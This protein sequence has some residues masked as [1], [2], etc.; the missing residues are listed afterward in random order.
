MVTKRKA[1]L[2]PLDDKKRIVVKIPE[3]PKFLMHLDADRDGKVDDDP[4]GLDVWT[5]G[6][7][8][9]G[10][11]ILVN[12][13]GKPTLIDNSDNKVN[14][15]ADLKDI[16]PLD[17][18]RTGPNPPAGWKV[19]LSVSAAD[20]KHIRIF[21]LR[22]AGG[23]EVIG[24][25]KGEKYVLPSLAFTKLEMGIE[26]VN[27]AGEYGGKPF[28]GDVVLTLS[29]DDKSSA[30]PTQTAKVRVA[31]W[32]MFNHFDKPE[33]VFVVTTLDNVGFVTA[34]TAAAGA[35]GLPLEKINGASWGGAGREDRWMQDIMEFGYS[36]LP[37]QPVLRNVMETPRGRELEGMPKTLVKADLGYVHP[38][39]VP[40]PTQ[41]SSLNSGGNLECTPPFTDRRGKT[42]PFGRIYCCAFRR[43]RPADTLAPGYLEFLKAQRLQPPIELDAGWLN[44]GH[45]DEIISF[46]PCSG[47]KGFKLLLSSP[48]LALGIVTA[49]KASRAKLLTGRRYTGVAAPGAEVSATDLLTK[50]IDYGGVYKMTGS[51]FIAHNYACQAKID[52]VR[53]KFVTEMGLDLSDIAEVPI[54][55]V[56]EDTGGGV[57][58]RSDALTA[59]MV[60]MLVLGNAC[61]APKPFGPQAAG[62]DL[63]ERSY[64]ATLA[65]CGLTVT[66]VDDWETYHLLQGEVHCGT[67]TL[68]TP[69]AKT[70]WWN[71]EL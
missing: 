48:K 55:Y 41:A 2:T 29:V 61:I 70:K 38:A 24:P 5:Y 66:F 33:K 14:D 71:A 52:T 53:S 1:E 22:T 7:G 51:E 18:R 64:S 9:K 23:V 25:A 69:A 21:D 58:G 59:G 42:F 35:A 46:V 63:F 10:A 12:C 30:P 62:V 65:A 16:A 39:P 44:V 8:K 36:E 50:G 37:G 28:S 13:N 19:T 27:Y 6:K 15:A 56:A 26:A 45:V 60:N 49:A 4:T 57:L 43:D 20:A 68:R 17:I 31:P 40:P 34:L 54:L 32:L 11:V 47:G 67:N 3:R